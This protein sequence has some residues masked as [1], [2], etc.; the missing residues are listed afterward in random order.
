MRELYEAIVI[1]NGKRTEPYKFYNEKTRDDFVDK[2]R[3]AGFEVRRDQ[4]IVMTAREAW[5]AWK[6]VDEPR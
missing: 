3:A 5:L 1:H 2:V 4:R 6:N